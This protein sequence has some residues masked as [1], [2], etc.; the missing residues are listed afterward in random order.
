MLESQKK[1]ESQQQRDKAISDLLH[2][3]VWLVDNG[4]CHDQL[5]LNQKGKLRT[6]QLLVTQI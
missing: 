4:L 1:N 2:V 5:Y 3:P 6:P